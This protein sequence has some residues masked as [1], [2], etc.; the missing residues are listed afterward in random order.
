M[1]FYVLRPFLLSLL[2]FCQP[3]HSQGVQ[4]LFDR[5]ASLNANETKEAVTILA[6]AWPS[7][8]LWGKYTIV[9]WNNTYDF[10]LSWQA[11]ETN[12]GWVG[13][14]PGSG[15]TNLGRTLTGLTKTSTVLCPRYLI[16][17][18]GKPSDQTDFIK[19]LND[20]NEFVTVVV[21]VM[22]FE[23]NYLATIEW[24]KEI[25]TRAAYR[26]YEFTPTGLVQAAQAVNTIGQ[27][28]IG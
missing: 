27:C 26:V 7:V 17:V 13:M 3:A 28:P 4:I 15:D 20:L 22:H 5:S 21:V 14:I 24:Y 18:D 12:I 6:R 2:L 16:M 10:D 1:L 8:D 19:V 11:D 25:E 9:P 23:R